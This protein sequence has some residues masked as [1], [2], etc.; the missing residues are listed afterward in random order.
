MSSTESSTSYSQAPLARASQ[1]P[2]ID[3][4]SMV[5]RD[6]CGDSCAQS[7]TSSKR[8]EE[9]VHDILYG[10]TSQAHYLVAPG[11]RR[12]LISDACS[13]PWMSAGS[14]F[15]G[16]FWTAN[17]PEF[18]TGRLVDSEGQLRSAAGV[19]TL[20]EFLEQTAPP[21]YSLSALACEGVIRRAERRGKPLPPMLKR[22]LEQVIA[23]G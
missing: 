14:V 19:S 5:S 22:A 15:H 20:S 23:R 18:Q 3:W 9:R 2:G 17:L 7:E 13:K 16:E 11:A 4:D 6:S 1:L 12:G 21:K 8:Q 10:R